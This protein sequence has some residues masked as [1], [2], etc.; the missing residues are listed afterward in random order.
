MKL[1]VLVDNNTYI[2]E[3]Y[4]GEPAVSYYIEDD[5]SK[6]LFDAGYSD[7]LIRN[8]E[9]MGLDLEGLN[10][11]V[12]SHGHEDHTRGLKYYFESDMQTHNLTIVAH[13][14]AFD[15]KLSD[16]KLIG[17]P[18]SREELDK[19]SKLILTKTPYEISNNIVFLGEIPVTNYFEQRYSIGETFSEGEII[20]DKLLDD[21][22]L[23]YKTS[24]GIY[25][26]TGCSHSGI[27]NIINYA[28]EVTGENRILGVIGGFHLFDVDDRVH[29]TIEYFKENNI[30]ELY[31]CHCTSFAVKAEIH[32]SIN[33]MEVGVGMVLDTSL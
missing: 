11:I 10:T 20:E 3:Y 33:I 24:K 30:T 4:I 29:K 28:K 22:A 23:V 14:N 19:H 5:N 15:P 21:S 26:I 7:V 31:P 17:S 16:G 6:I 9:D 8:A 12:I 32:K 1:T 25:I 13:P 2:D 27:C 18:L